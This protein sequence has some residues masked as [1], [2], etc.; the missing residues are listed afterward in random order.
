MAI[1]N[2]AL[3]G[4]TTTATGNGT[5]ITTSGVAASPAKQTINSGIGT[6]NTCSYY[7]IDANGAWE[8]GYGTSNGATS[9]DRTTVVKNS[10]GGTT[11][12]TLS[13]GT[14]TIYHGMIPGVLNGDH[15]VTGK[16]SISGTKVY[17]MNITAV[18][19]SAYNAA[20]GDI[21]L[22]DTSAGAFTVTLPASPVT[23]D[24]IHIVDVGNAFSTYNLT[25]GR[26]GNNI[27]T[28]ASDLVC[29]I[30]GSYIK[31]IYSSAK[32]W[33][34]EMIPS[35]GNPAGTTLTTVAPV[36]TTSGSQQDFTIPAGVKRIVMSFIGFSTNGTAVPVVQL[37][38]S[39]GVQVTSYNGA[40]YNLGAS[41]ANISSGFS[42]GA[43]WSTAITMHGFLEMML[44]DATNHI[45]AVSGNI[46]RSDSAQNMIM[47][48]TKSLGAEITTVRLKTTDTFDAGSVGISYYQ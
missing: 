14:H 13:A 5:T 26:N 34:I 20:A 43:A 36:A 17:A 48:G 39:G 15:D 30:N 47:S 27:G 19:T 11:K 6:G 28:V 4:E 23:N 41:G 8:F 37:G 33:L 9:F 22:C 7:L 21:V 29:D 25:I 42:L 46:G 44:V 10:S 16:L 3:C 40:A 35:S 32:G 12:I 18:K 2:A 45:W 1:V 24:P 31:L 38:T